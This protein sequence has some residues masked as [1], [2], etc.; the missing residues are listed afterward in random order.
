MIEPFAEA[1]QRHGHCRQ[2]RADLVIERRKLRHNIG[3]HEEHQRRH[4]HHQHAGIDQRRDQLFAEGERDALEA[5]IALQHLEQVAG[6]LTGQQRRCVHHRKAA[7]RLKSRRERF[8]SLHAPRY[9]VQLGRKVSVLLVLR[10]HLQRSHN[11]QPGPDQSKKLLIEDQ[12]RFQLDFAP[13]DSRKPRAGA[14]A[15]YVVSGMC[16]AGTQFLGSG[17]RLHLLLHASTLIGQLDDE[18]CHACSRR[19]T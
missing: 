12:E 7:L 8:A 17:R 14:D 16:K 5:D 9:V 6:A 19:H 15:E 11:G 13:L 3:K 18:L 2:L 4:Q 10:Q 1:Q